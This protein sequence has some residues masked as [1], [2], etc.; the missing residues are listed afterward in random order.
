MGRMMR[1]TQRRIESLI[2]WLLALVFIA[3]L[4]AGAWYVW[5]EV[6]VV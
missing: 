3:L 6:I 1:K 4:G 5:T 2:S